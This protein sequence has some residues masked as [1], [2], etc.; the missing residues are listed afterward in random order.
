[1]PKRKAANGQGCIRQR[2]DGSWEG[3]L[4]I[5]RDPGTGK[6]KQKSFYGKTQ[7]E[8]RKQMTAFSADLDKGIYMEPSKLTVGQWL[9]IWHK[10]YLGGVKHTTVSQYGTQIEIHIKP[11]I[12][13]VKLTQ[14]TAPMI[15][16]M[17]NAEKRARDADPK[18]GLSAKSIRNL[19]GVLHKAL[20]Q[21]VKL[22]YLR[23]N[24][25]DACEPPRAEKHE[26][27]PL[28]TEEISAF[29]KACEGHKY[30]K[31]YTVVLFSGMRI[32]EA[33]GL[34][35]SCVDFENGTITI[36]HQLQKERVRGGG[37]T[38]RL[39]ETKTSTTRTLTLAAHV[40]AVLREV[41]REQAQYRL[42]LGTEWKN[43]M[44]LVFTHE[45]GGHL[46]YHTVWACFK[47]IVESAGFSSARIH[48]LRHTFASISLESGDDLKTVS[49][50]L[51]HSKIGTTGDI[52]A[53]VTEKMRRE[54]AARMDAFI[55]SV[56]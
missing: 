21:A 46:T 20:H 17:Y 27:Q 8:V 40:M 44:N 10:E 39:F 19:H 3:R 5:G 41:K 18:A 49:K 22:G 38:Y 14:L 33:M 43:E 54:S 9:D 25:C 35:W 50:A 4:S 23:S 6:L 52:Y 13:A 16:S 45:N 24:P 1:M 47:R 48:D 55:Q 42:M 28:S 34:R 7:A 31:L 2:K 12:G 30:E 53:H 56:K 26:I 51:G 29:L 11:R 37:G 32:G 15:Q 36:D